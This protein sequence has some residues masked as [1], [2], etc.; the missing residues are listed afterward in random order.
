MSAAGN[1]CVGI[2]TLA[3]VINNP[4]E[5]PV[6]SSTDDLEFCDGSSA[7]LQGPVGLSSYLW[8]NGDTTQTTVVNSS[9][10][11]TL[12]IQGTC[13]PWTSAPVNIISHTVATPTATDI[14]IA[15][16]TSGTINATSGTNVTWYDAATGGNLLGSGNAFNTPVLTNNTI[17]YA[18][19]T[20]IFGGFLTATKHA[21][22]TGNSQYS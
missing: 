1:N 6:V 7:T 16:G 17:Y 8:S 20:E 4:D 21:Y 9:S 13:Q 5:T 11:V 3:T 22:H 2:S 10:T 18:Q 15:T 19:S 14:Y 12:T